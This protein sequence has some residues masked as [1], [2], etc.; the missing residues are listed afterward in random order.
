[1]K[2]LHY[3]L[4]LLLLLPS[5]AMADLFWVAVLAKGSGFTEQ[6]ILSNTTLGHL[7]PAGKEGME[8]GLCHY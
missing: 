6:R 3:L 7:I 4:V 5:L 2:I 8:R 1:M